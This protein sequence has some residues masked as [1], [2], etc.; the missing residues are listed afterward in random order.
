[1]N[2][3]LLLLSYFISDFDLVYGR[4]CGFIRTC[5]SDSL[6]FSVAISF[7]ILLNYHSV[8]LVRQITLISNLSLIAPSYP[9][10]FLQGSN[11]LDLVKFKDFQNIFQGPPK[12]FP[13][14]TKK[15][16]RIALTVFK[17]HLNYFP[18]TIQLISRITNI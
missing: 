13:R 11:R 12:L 9:G 18:R 7:K 16:S 17:D 4:L 3:S 5:I 10:M 15:K 6:A 14:T 1:M 8:S 2:L